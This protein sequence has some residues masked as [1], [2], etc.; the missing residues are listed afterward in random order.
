MGLAS[1][2]WVTAA[3][4]RQFD[5]DSIGSNVVMSVWVS[6]TLLPKTAV[7]CPL[8]HIPPIFFP[9][10]LFASPTRMDKP[11][12]GSVKGTDPLCAIC[13]NA[14]HVIVLPTGLKSKW[15]EDAKYKG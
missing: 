8:S 9:I 11:I 12:W 6:G 5:P 10:F 15:V 4:K 2:G 13:F 7:L 14:H 1:H 3:S